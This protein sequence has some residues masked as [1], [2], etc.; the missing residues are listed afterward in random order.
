MD[1][2]F[3][4][5]GESEGNKTKKLQGTDNYPLTEVGVEQTIKLAE[6]LQ[7]MTANVI[8]SSDLTRAHK[9]AEAVLHHQDAALITTELLRE[10]HLGPLQGKNREEIVREFPH[11]ENKDLLL[12]GLDGAETTEDITN[13]CKELLAGLRKLDRDDTVLLVSHGGFISIFLVFIIAGDK[14]PAVHRPFRISNTGITKLTLND[15]IIA[16]DFVNHDH[17]LL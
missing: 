5:H 7:N 12:S 15:D 16:I 3:I 4:R 14:W 13:R 17:H 11:L 8:W 2:Y 9:T 1:I 6:A 10:I